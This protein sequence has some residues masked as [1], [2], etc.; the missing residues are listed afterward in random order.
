MFCT[1]Y[2]CKTKKRLYS[3]YVLTKY[4]ATDITDD[5]VIYIYSIFSGDSHTD[6]SHIT[7]QR[8][9]GLLR[10]VDVRGSTRDEGGFG[11]CI[12]YIVYKNEKD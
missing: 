10:G 9:R 4:R 2:C 12:S 8:P 11:V 7:K 1:K 5:S 3:A 6:S